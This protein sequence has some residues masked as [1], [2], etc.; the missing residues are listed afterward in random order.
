MNGLTGGQLYLLDMDGTLY[1]DDTLFDGTLEFLRYLRESGGNYLYLTN[2][3]CLGADQYVEKLARLG[4]PAA[5]A[6]F[7]N[8]VDITIWR[9][10]RDG[11]QEKKIYALGTASFRRQL[12]QAGFCVTD[13]LED[14]I[15]VLVVA[16]DRELT[17]QKVEDAC[18]LLSRGVA[19]YATSPDLRCPTSYGFM[20]DCGSIWQMLENATGRR[21]VITGK[22]EPDMAFLAMERLGYTKEN[23]WIVGDRLYTDIACGVNAGIGSILVL[24][25][26]ATRADAAASSTPPTCIFENIRSLLTA[27][28]KNDAARGRIC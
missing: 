6:D 26:E 5:H 13:R 18:V 7:L 28:Q 10:R 25:G 19:Y 17:F 3:S 15:K 8:A 4:I 23:T 2:N 9:L 12:S 11:L 24:T 27:I 1:I 20:P 16:F 22:P 21:P 14:G